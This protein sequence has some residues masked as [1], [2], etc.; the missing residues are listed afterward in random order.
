MTNY[1]YKEKVLTINKE[2]CSR[3]GN[4]FQKLNGIDK[5]SF[6][7]IRNDKNEDLTYLYK[8]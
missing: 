4:I 1:K 5:F 2:I 7:L 6:I 8:K 3:S